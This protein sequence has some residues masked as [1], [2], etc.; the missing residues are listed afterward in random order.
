MVGSEW[1]LVIQ[2]KEFDNLYDAEIRNND[3]YCCCDDGDTSCAGADI[4]A[5][6]DMR[7][8]ND[9]KH[10]EPYYM[11]RVNFQGSP[12]TTM[13]CPVPG[14]TESSVEHTPITT[15]FLS[16]LNVTLSQSE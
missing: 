5:V 16:H 6:T 1:F 2:I 12:S 8:F 4:D 10:C 3:R 11:L 13:M 14:W 9:D 7:C 15:S